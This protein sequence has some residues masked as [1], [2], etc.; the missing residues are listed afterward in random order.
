MSVKAAS[1]LQT[2]RS[3]L[4]EN[5][6]AMRR[7]VYRESQKRGSGDLANVRAC[8]ALR[9]ILLLSEATC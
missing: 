4:V 6:L 5:I 3:P 8:A 2:L 7:S 9:M 1:M